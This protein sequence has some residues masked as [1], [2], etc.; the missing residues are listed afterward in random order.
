MDFGYWGT[1]KAGRASAIGTIVLSGVVS[2]ILMV[3]VW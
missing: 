1:L 3:I 2:L